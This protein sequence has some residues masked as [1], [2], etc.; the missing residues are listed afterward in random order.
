MEAVKK[1]SYKKYVSFFS[2]VSKSMDI[3]NSLEISYPKARNY[4]DANVEDY[5]ALRLDRARINKDLEKIM[6]EKIHEY[7]IARR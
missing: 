5:I 4:E 2:G 6:L 1:S 3:G 7:D